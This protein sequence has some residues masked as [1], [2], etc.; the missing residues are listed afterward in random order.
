MS[1]FANT[2][3]GIILNDGGLTSTV[4]HLRTTNEWNRDNFRAA[5]IANRYTNPT[6]MKYLETYTWEEIDTAYNEILRS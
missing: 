4:R 2:I 3:L 5:C 1:T 6:T